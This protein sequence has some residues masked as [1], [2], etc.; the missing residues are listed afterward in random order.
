MKRL[1]GGLVALALLLGLA[2]QGM[3]ERAE[4]PRYGV[5]RAGEGQEVYS[6]KMVAHENRVGWYYDGVVVEILEEDTDWT[7]VGIGAPEG[8]GRVEGYIKTNALSIGGSVNPSSR[9]G[10]PGRVEVSEVDLRAEPDYMA[11]S[12]LA[13]P[14]GTQVYKLGEYDGWAHVKIHDM[15]GYIHNQALSP[16]NEFYGAEAAIVSA[17]EGVQAMVYDTL[18]AEEPSGWLRSGTIINILEVHGERALIRYGVES[19]RQFDTI[20]H[21]ADMIPSGSF[22][23]IKVAVPVWRLAPADG[24]RVTLRGAASEDGESLGAFLPGTLVDKLGEMDG[25]WAYVRV[26]EQEGFVP[27]EVLEETDIQVAMSDRAAPIPPQGYAAVSAPDLN[28]EGEESMLYIRLEPDEDAEVVVE[29]WRADRVPVIL[30]CDLG[31]WLQVSLGSYFDQGYLS[32][33]YPM[34]TVWLDDLR[35]P[36]DTRVEAGSYT[37]GK[38]IPAGL[39]TF[40]VAEGGEGSIQVEDKDAT[41]TYAPPPGAPYTLLV[42][43]GAS[44]IITGDGVL[45]P[46]DETTVLSSAQ[47]WSYSGTGRFLVGVQFPALREI[48]YS[49][50]PLDDS[51]PGTATVEPGIA[52]NTREPARTYPLPTGQDEHI[53]PLP[54]SFIEVINGDLKTYFGNG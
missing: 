3:A 14:Q 26:D 7:K 41:Q 1:L 52:I 36:A 46:M 10:E 37:A 9:D 17:A 44:V 12:L 32:K 42:A 34:E 11:P 53:Y 29:L 19:P 38:D 28:S 4:A 47:D 13:Y 35:V 27:V 18:D 8:P 20:M 23:E 16:W 6:T 31:D 2:A 22:N 24:A 49:G 45:G 54:G 51:Q 21:V 15:Y 5:I 48:K 43:D 25:G 50:T 33:E 30:L 40:V 39:Y